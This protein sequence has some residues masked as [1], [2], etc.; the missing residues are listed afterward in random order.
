MTLSRSQ[1]ESWNP[2][3]LNDIAEA[4][5]AFG[6]KVEGLFDRYVDAVTRVND[7]YWE[8]RAAEAAQDRANADRKTALS[9]VDRLG[10][11]AARARQGFFELDAPL[12]RA[13]NAIAGAEGDLFSVAGDLR[14]CDTMAEPSPERVAALQQWQSE[15]VSA[16][17]DVENADRAVRDA[18]SSCR[19]ELRAMFVSAAAL[20]SEQG[21]ADGE[22][23]AA[24]GELNAESVRRLVE[25]GTLDPAQLASL[26]EGHE[27][28]IPASHMEYLNQVARSLDG[29]S[30]QEIDELMGKL[31]EEGSR[32]L[33]NSL[34][35]VSNTQ[36]T[37]SVEGDADVPTRG[38]VG[39]LPDKIRESLTRDDLVVRSF[40]MTGGTGFWN[41][42]L[43]GVADNQAIARIVESGDQQYMN[44]SELDRRL[45]DA[46]RQYLD[47]QVAHEQN[48]NS[49]F[50][51]FVVDGR[52]SSGDA[53]TEPIFEAVGADKTA[54]LDAVSDDKH[55]ADLVRD[56]LSHDWTDDGK[57]AS[58]MFRFSEQD[59][60]VQDPNNPDDV[61]RA[62]QT[63]R[64]MASVGEHLSSSDAWKTLSDIPGADGN[65]A[66]QVNP[67]LLRTLSRSM[68]E[69]IPG[70]TGA[71]MP[72]RPGFA[73]G[74]WADPNTNGQY[75]GTA[76]I[77]ALMNTDE[78]AGKHFTGA[79]QQTIFDSLGA[80]AQNP[81]DRH[82]SYNL[83]TA[84]RLEGLIDRGLL[85]ETQDEY[86]DTAEAAK[87]AYERKAAAYTLAT[88]VGT[89]GLDKA[90][91][92]D[93]FNALVAAGGDT[94]KQA[95]IGA[96]PGEAVQ[97]VLTGP[98]F[99]AAYHTVLTAV[100]EIPDEV[101]AAHPGLFD[102]SGKL[103]SYE[104]LAARSGGFDKWQDEL[105]DAFIQVGEYDHGTVMQDSY[106]Q[107]IL[108]DG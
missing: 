49:K 83:V 58:S 14:V 37:A 91:G 96:P 33:A 103:T 20:G 61:A 22:L 76:N 81:S 32:A 2:G 60:A 78:V 93:V 82:A 17:G 3:A 40:E 28:T 13:R 77:F 54:V 9:V 15:I 41:T 105:R 12:V 5:D 73:P 90:W 46:G 107:V 27:A 75:T 23:I 25:A 26:A 4:W 39:L 18:L 38:D 92:G 98:S 59:F 24:G 66:G 68:S 36:V 86:Q 85:I 34:Q 79:A 31:P 108:N 94:L 7:G 106:R 45:L 29:K 47:A 6:A 74:K 89:Y 84:G 8:G 97:A 67:G 64:I 10:G 51:A 30:P 99:P 44:G 72:D 16:A 62:T 19:S 87:A 21:R 69:Y 48:P 1:I 102:A 100:P 55:G 104:E 56:M 63:G 53:I 95:I 88:T 80:Y 11:L 71:E 43:N 52:G 35:I 65:S 57:A 101:R 42:G 70:L 50:E